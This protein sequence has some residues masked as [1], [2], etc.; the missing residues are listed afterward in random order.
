VDQNRVKHPV[1]PQGC[2]LLQ[3][4]ELRHQCGCACIVGWH[5]LSVSQLQVL[6]LAD[7]RAC[8]CTIVS[9]HTIHKVAAI[10]AVSDRVSDGG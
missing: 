1:Q 10:N 2:Q 9:L 6:Q 3:R 4:G 8:G 5:D 7:A